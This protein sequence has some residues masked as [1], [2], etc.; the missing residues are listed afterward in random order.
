MVMQG[1]GNPL[2]ALAGLPGLSGVLSEVAKA[3][4]ARWNQSSMFHKLVAAGAGAGLAYYLHTKG[5]ADAAVAVAGVAGA[6]ATS[7]LLHYPTVARQV[8]NGGTGSAAT[9]AQALP[10]AQVAAMN[11]MAQ[12]MMGQ[13]LA[14]GVP[15]Q[16][17]PGGPQMAAPIPGAPVQPIQRQA[18]VQPAMPFSPGQPPVMRAG[19]RWDLLGAEL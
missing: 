19:G 9:T 16:R 6:Y 10:P 2:A 4:I 14:G 11:Q 5:M 17:F 12:Q 3:P 13:G 1:F 15:A 7:M 8:V 18:P